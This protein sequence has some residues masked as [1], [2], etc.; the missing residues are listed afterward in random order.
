MVW[1]LNGFAWL[2]YKN[3]KYTTPSLYIQIFLNHC[4]CDRTSD[5][6]KSL[7]IKIKAERGYPVGRTASTKWCPYLFFTQIHNLN[8]YIHVQA[9]LWSYLK[10]L[11]LCGSGSLSAEASLP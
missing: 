3:G 1:L 9:Y 2:R 8:Q 11:C 7:S 4:V 6:L 5:F 10:A